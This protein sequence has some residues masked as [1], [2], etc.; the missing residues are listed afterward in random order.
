MRSEFYQA[1][2]NSEAWHK[3]KERIIKQRG[4]LC[5]KCGANT[6]QLELHHLTYDRLG[7][8]LDTDLQ[9]LCSW[10]HVQADQVRRAVNQAASEERITNARYYNA[11]DTYIRKVYGAHYVD[12]PRDYMI[13]EFDKWLEEKEREDRG[14]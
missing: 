5:Q 12:R 10:C 1:Y 14:W 8:E 13:R 6:V 9:L 3:L 7:H 11:M 2:I 4:Y